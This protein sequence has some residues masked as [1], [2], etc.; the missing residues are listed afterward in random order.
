ET[1]LQGVVIRRPIEAG[2]HVVLARPDELDRNARLTRRRNRFGDG[3][4]LDQVIGNRIGPP[5]EAAAC[6]E[7]VDEDLLG[8]QADRLRDAHLI[9]RV[10]LLAVPD[11]ATV[12]IE[13]DD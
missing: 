10:K 13:L 2:A 7:L 3:G 1:R 4:R 9:D 6:E 5:T 12:R 8:L 11:L